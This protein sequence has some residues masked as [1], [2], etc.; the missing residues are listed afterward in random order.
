MVDS[1]DKENK[2]C[3]LPGEN[4]NHIPKMVKRLILLGVKFSLYCRINQNKGLGFLFQIPIS[5][6]SKLSID[7]DTMEPF[8]ETD[9]KSGHSIY[10]LYKVDVK[11]F[12][13]NGRT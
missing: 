10:Y 13:K 2:Y 6:I 12:M 3:L 1:L 4:L 5:E 9:S 7:T 11:S 8:L